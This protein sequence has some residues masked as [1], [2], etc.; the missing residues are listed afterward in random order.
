MIAIVGS[1]RAGKTTLA[2]E[3]GRE[4]EVPVFHADDLMA[5][6]WSGASDAMAEAIGLA[7]APCIWEGVMVVRALRKLLEA[8]PGRPVDRCIVLERP[9]V[10][11]TAGQRAMQ[12]GCATILAGIEPEL[13][14]RGVEL[15]RPVR[16]VGS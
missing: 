15:V 11:L 7:V 4:R 8:G 5:L 3:L 2:G 10:P 16:M 14:R 9:W 6:G 12:R 1:P 13:V